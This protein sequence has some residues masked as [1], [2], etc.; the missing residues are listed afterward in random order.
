MRGA[1]SA[2]AI[3]ENFNEAEKTAAHPAE[4]RFFQGSSRSLLFPTDFAPFVKSGL[5]PQAL[6]IYGFPRFGA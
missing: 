2:K 6:I 5:A 3:A 4:R 1:L